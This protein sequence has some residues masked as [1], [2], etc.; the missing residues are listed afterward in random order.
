LS[1][2]DTSDPASWA[3]ELLT[4]V[5]DSLQDL[6]EVPVEIASVDPIDRTAERRE[7]ISTLG[8]HHDLDTAQPVEVDVT[9]TA[10]TEAFQFFLLNRGNQAE[11]ISTCANSLVDAVQEALGSTPFPTCPGH[12]HPAVVEQRSGQVYW[13]C[14]DARAKVL[15]PIAPGSL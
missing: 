10:G 3:R 12:S 11:R 13:S 2:S 1:S 5:L 6:T 8:Q 4:R 15:S 9:G 14:P 7:A